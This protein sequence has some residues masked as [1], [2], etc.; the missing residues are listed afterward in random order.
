MKTFISTILFALVLTTGLFA[1]QTITNEKH[2]RILTKVDANIYDVQFLDK[3]GNVVQKGQYWRDGES[4]KPHG[5]W[6]L[7]ALN[8]NKVTTRSTFDKGEQLSVETIIDGMLVSVDKQQLVA[9]K[10]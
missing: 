6:T 3:E 2:Q 4:L 10:Q 5:T 9:K 1:Q 8:S 7:F